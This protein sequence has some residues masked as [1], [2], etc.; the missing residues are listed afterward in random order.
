MKKK[1]TDY[2]ALIELILLFK[3]YA[4]QNQQGNLEGFAFWML[5]QLRQAELKKT[6]H[7]AAQA[8]ATTGQLN[9]VLLRLARQTEYR[10]KTFFQEDP[11]TFTDFRILQ[12]VAAL[13]NPRKIEVIQKVQL[14][15]TTAT[16]IMKKLVDEG[17]LWE[18]G[19]EKDKRSKRLGLTDNG[20]AYLKSKVAKLNAVLPELY[21]Q[22]TL[23]EQSR[24]LQTLRLIDALP[25]LESSAPG[26]SNCWTQS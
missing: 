25:R 14:E 4:T 6:K 23:E 18:I 8:L 3:H 21:P 9:E 10:M 12:A 13:Q 17:Y 7:A 11:I 15:T 26:E 20:Q 24:L 16:A 19:D 2:D 22:L 5:R 1:G